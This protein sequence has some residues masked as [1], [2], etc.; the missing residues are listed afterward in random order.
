[1]VLQKQVI[2]LS[3][4]A[5]EIFCRFKMTVSVISAKLLAAF[6]FYLFFSSHTPNLRN[7]IYTTFLRKA[8]AGYVEQFRRTKIIVNV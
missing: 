3:Q 5:G 6:Q 8:V 4:P 2:K 1:M 7:I